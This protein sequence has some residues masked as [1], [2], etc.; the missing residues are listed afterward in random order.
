MAAGAGNQQM[1]HIPANRKKTDFV[2]EEPG[3]AWFI[4]A[5]PV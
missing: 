5:K 3:G 1:S 4:P 2:L